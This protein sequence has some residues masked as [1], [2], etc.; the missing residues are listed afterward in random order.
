MIARISNEY[1]AFVGY[2]YP[3][4]VFELS[5]SVAFFAEIK[6]PVALFADNYYPV[7]PSVNKINVSVRGNGKVAWLVGARTDV[8][9]GPG[10]N[11]FQGKRT[12]REYKG[13]KNEQQYWMNMDMSQGS[14]V[15]Q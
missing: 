4:G 12:G 8:K 15:N 10:V 11:A 3:E 5:L 9:K 13:K 6:F 7:V 2:V 14:S 1:P